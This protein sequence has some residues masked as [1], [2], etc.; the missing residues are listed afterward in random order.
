MCRASR[1]STGSSFKMEQDS[2]FNANYKNALS[3]GLKVGVYHF[4][5]AITVTEAKEEAEFLCKILKDYQKPTFWVAIDYEFDDR[6]TRKKCTHGSDVVNAFCDV[7]KSYGYQPCIYANLEMLKNYVKSPKYPLWVAQ[8]NSTCDYKGPKVMW[9]YT[10][11]GRVDGISS[12]NTNNNSA[13]VDLSHVY[14]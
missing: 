13:N 12:K 7:V 3:A 1:T 11:S 6:L 14:K 4:S 10:S 5:Q 8:Y 2:T 9:Q